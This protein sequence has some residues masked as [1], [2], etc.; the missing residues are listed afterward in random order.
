[1]NVTPMISGS[2]KLI[3]AFVRTFSLLRSISLL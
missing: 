3:T 2:T 1:M